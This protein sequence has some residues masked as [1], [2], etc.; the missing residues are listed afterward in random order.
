MGRDILISAEYSIRTAFYTRNNGELNLW[1]IDI[2]ILNCALSILY[3]PTLGENWVEYFFPRVFGANNCS[4][5]RNWNAY[6]DTRRIQNYFIHRRNHE[7]FFNRKSIASADFRKLIDT[8]HVYYH[9]STAL[10]FNERFSHQYTLRLDVINL[11][12]GGG[13]VI[14]VSAYQNLVKNEIASPFY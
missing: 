13:A 7:L 10:N 12:F 6:W 2:C 5:N 1:L 3:F 14:A 9:F 4:S 11:I 8:T